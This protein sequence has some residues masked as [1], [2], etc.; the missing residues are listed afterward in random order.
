MNLIEEIDNLKSKVNQDDF[1]ILG[2]WQELL[3]SELAKE[4]LKGNKA[5]VNLI[6][7]C[8][9]VIVSINNRLTNER[10]IK[11]IERLLLFEKREWTETLL[12][13]LSPSDKALNYVKGEVNYLNKQ[14]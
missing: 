12:R 13:A 5:I 14:L 7:H 2:S 11:E 8:K 4:D 3:S 1:K 9:S 10:D 6:D